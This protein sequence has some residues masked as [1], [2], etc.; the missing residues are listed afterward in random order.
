MKLLK[1]KKPTLTCSWKW[2]NH[3]TLN[4]TWCLNRWPGPILR[5]PL[6]IV[7]PC[8][9]VN[10]NNRSTATLLLPKFVL[11]SHVLKER[12]FRQLQSGEFKSG[13]PQDDIRMAFGN[14]AQLSQRYVYWRNETLSWERQCGVVVKIASLVP[15]F[16][17]R[18]QPRVADF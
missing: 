17:L 10:W 8:P 13:L 16:L 3:V 5:S 9:Y 7:G 11:S 6:I 15:D 4:V 2:E 14:L 12:V 18:C 1:S